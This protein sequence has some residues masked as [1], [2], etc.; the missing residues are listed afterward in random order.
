MNFTLGT[1]ES[2][3]WAGYGDFKKPKF[4]CQNRSAGLEGGASTPSGDWA[5]Q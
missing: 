3:S 5:V 4:Y 1:P 2:E